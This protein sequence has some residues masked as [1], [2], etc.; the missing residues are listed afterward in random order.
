MTSN[1]YFL[2]SGLIQDEK[3]SLDLKTFKMHKA[4]AAEVLAFRLA[5][6]DQAQKELDE[7]QMD[8]AAKGEQP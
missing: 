3:Q 7:L 8:G 1:I 5:Q 4:K 6:L 2:I